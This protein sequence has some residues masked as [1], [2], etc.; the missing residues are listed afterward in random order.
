MS[1]HTYR[2]LLITCT[3]IPLRLAFDDL[4]AGTS[5]TW[6]TID[7]VVNFSFFIDILVNFFS[8]YYDGEYVLV[9]NR[10]VFKI[11]YIHMFIQLIAKSYLKTWFFVDIVSII[12]LDEA[13]NKVS[14]NRLVRLARVPK[15]YKLVKMSRLVRMLK[16]LQDRNRLVKYLGEVF[17]IGIGFERLLFFILLTFVLCHIAACL[18]VMLANFDDGVFNWIRYNRVEDESN[19]G[20]YTTAF[21]FTVTTITTVG[22]GDFSG[23]T[24]ME[25]VFCI[26]LMLIGASGFSFAA[27]SLSSL[28]SNLDA[29]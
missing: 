24:N 18:W 3:F 8:S 26:C 12:P 23:H 17:K 20:L 25:K 4:V 9:E 10:R 19:V 28:M 21:Y 1:N 14:Y 11:F 2:L 22:Y 16:I 15:L 29:S 5:I 27:G 13:L 6:Y 7:T